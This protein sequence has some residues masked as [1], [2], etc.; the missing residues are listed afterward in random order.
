MHALRRRRKIVVVAGAGISVSAGIPDFRSANGLFAGLQKEH[1]LKG[2]SGKQLFDASVYKDGT[3]TSQFHDMVRKLSKMSKRAKPTAFHHMLARLAKEGRLLRLY[4]QNVDG[5]E[6]Q[7]PPLETEIPLPHKGPWP[8]TVQLHGGLEK[9]MCQKCREIL[10]FDPI[11]FDG[12]ETPTCPRCRETDD[13]RTNDLGRRSH[14]I[15]RLRP[16]IVLYNEQNP[17]EEAIGA[18]SAAD[19]RTRP[20]A[21]VVVG[22]SMKIPGV[23]RIVSEMCKI[24]RDRREGTTI[25][26][27]PDPEPTGPSFENCWDLIVRGGSDEVANLVNLR[28]WDDPNIDDPDAPT[29]YTDSDVERITA[30]QGEIRINVPPSPLKKTAVAAVM[31][32][33]RSQSGDLQPA[34]QPKQQQITPPIRIKLKV[35]EKSAEAEKQ[36]QQMQ[37]RV[38]IPPLQKTKNAASSGRK[39]MDVLGKENVEKN[40]KPKTSYKKKEFSKK[41]DGQPQQSKLANKI[42]KPEAAKTNVQVNIPVKKPSESLFKVEAASIE[43][44][45]RKWTQQPGRANGSLMMGTGPSPGMFGMFQSDMKHQIPT[46]GMTSSSTTPQDTPDPQTPSATSLSDGR[47]S[48]LG[49]DHK[50]TVSPTSIPRGMAG[51]LH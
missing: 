45:Y 30:R 18:V 37:V 17:D 12:E 51:L 47:R 6:T 29:E 1:K 44:D 48:S 49:Y 41:S 33:P 39:L 26:I 43:S 28:Q 21:V 40:R 36:K 9:M 16:R 46:P 7:M 11:L 27:N 5:L 13:I 42:T 31:T 32:P 15:G 3:S 8:Q 22:T 23:K 2:G 4:T 34:S 14:G 35:G 24:V 19:M 50:E 25:W 20:D 10:D 38:D